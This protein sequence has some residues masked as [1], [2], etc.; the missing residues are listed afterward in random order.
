[1][2]TIDGKTPN[3]LIREKSPY[4]RQHADNPVDWYPWGEEAFEKARREDKPIFLS[5]GYSTCHWCHVMEHE[6]FEDP[7]VARLLNDAFVCIKV[8]REER[9]DIDAVYMTVCQ[10]LT[11]SGGWPLT[12]IMTPDKQPFFAATY[13]PREGRFGRM[14]LLELI[15][16]IKELWQHQREELLRG[17]REITRYLQQ[18]QSTAASDSL[19]P[20]VLEQTYRQLAREYDETHGGFGQAPKFP[21][22]HNLLFLLRYYDRTGE[23][24]ALDMVVHTLRQMRMG[25]IF[26]H[27]G[28]GFH[29]YA[30][31]QR[32]LVPHFEK[33]LYDQAMLV[34]A[35]LEAFQVSGE[36]LFQQTVREVLTYVLRDMQHPEGGFY[37]AED[38]DSE[39]EEGKFYLWREEEIRQWLTPEEFR[40]VVDVFGI[41]AEGNFIHETGQASRGENILHLRVDPDR[42]PD[43]LGM[44]PGVLESR[45]ETI[46]QKLFRARESRVR[47]LKDDKILTD[48]NG[49]MIAAFARA[50][51]VLQEPQYV[52]AARNAV[53]FIQERLYRDGQ[54]YHRFR[55]GETAIPAYLDDY[56]Y[57]IWGLLE[58]YEADCDPHYLEWAIDLTRMVQEQFLDEAQGG[59]YFTSA[60]A[61]TILVRKKE[62]QDGA[63][64]SG[65]SVMAFNL[66]RL[67]R[68]TADPSLEQVAGGIFRAFATPVKKY[69][70]AYTFL[71]LA[72]DFAVGPTRELV[73]VFPDEAKGQPMLRAIQ[74]RFLPRTVLLV[75]S[76]GTAAELAR[77][78]PFTETL[79]TRDGQPTAYLCQNFQCDLPVNQLD[80][81]LAKLDAFTA[82]QRP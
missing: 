48:W 19:T 2:F 10:M 17:A 77:L 46:R 7:L 21:S 37:S 78:A 31:D 73:L 11:G 60:R 58:L 61:E 28:F 56:A 44:D 3:R 20:E 53:W 54:L 15:P 29:R 47:P 64:P 72:Y 45:L 13:I 81:L 26:D 43:V 69:P 59:F 55:E 65:N 5:I 68:M 42:L 27:L 74:Q 80:A 33:M 41:R 32:W 75:K 40:L 12:I 36:P 38:A 39:G 30:T 76:P 57:L 67:A 1:M 51:R 23:P 70:Q 62:A 71:L 49:L 63:I 6:S 82:K 16:R 66:L 9:P 25:G 14:G 24:K 22:P 18:T 4:L 52:Q 50:G 35:Y 8:D 79:T 34:L